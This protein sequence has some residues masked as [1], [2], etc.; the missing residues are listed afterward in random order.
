[1]EGVLESAHFVRGSSLGD[2]LFQ[3]ICGDDYLN[4]GCIGSE[5]DAI[6]HKRQRRENLFLV[7]KLLPLCFA[8]P[9]GYKVLAPSP[10]VL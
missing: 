5:Q 4:M 1:M 6:Q 9:S 2:N 10:G 8:H 7:L 3:S